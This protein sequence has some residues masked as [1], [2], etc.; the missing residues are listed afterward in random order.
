[1]SKGSARLL[2]PVLAG[3]LVLLG[4][5]TASPQPRPASGPSSGP[6]C[7]EVRLLVSVRGEYSLSDRARKAGSG[8]VVG[9]YSFQAR[10]EG[11]LEPDGDDF[12]L[13]HLKT[14]VLEWRLREK[15]GPQGRETHLEAPGSSAPE[16]YLNY[17]LRDAN[18]IE[19]DFGLEGLIS[20]P[21]HDFPDKVRLL[22]PRSPARPDGIPGDHYDD[23][24]F[25]GTNRIVLPATD[26]A[27]RKPERDFSWE[28]ER[29]IRLADPRFGFTHRHAVEAVV[30]L[31]AR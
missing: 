11:R 5:G 15:A 31:A 17:V 13:V 8:P 24:V 26:L 21:L 22:L 9:E 1:M 6:D 20:V 10:W 19:F 4:P 12:L 16:L 18:S 14:D 23:F 28:W 30:V 29:V 27:R 25:K 7:W 2:L 3:V